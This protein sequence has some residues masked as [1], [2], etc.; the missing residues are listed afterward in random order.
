MY[1][2]IICHV[3]SQISAVCSKYS[4]GVIFIFSDK[5]YA[6]LVKMDP[7]TGCGLI[8]ELY[9][10]VYLSNIAREETISKHAMDSNTNGVITVYKLRKKTKQF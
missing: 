7:Y 5:S 1:A 2:F 10:V 8:L 6:N 3:T 4:F 9:F